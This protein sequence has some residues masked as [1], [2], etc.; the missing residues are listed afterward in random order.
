MNGHSTSRGHVEHKSLDDRLGELGYTPTLHRTLSV[1]QNVAIAMADVSPTMAVFLLATGALGI[2]G[3]GTLDAMLVV[4]VVVMM[5]SLCL[6]ELGAMYPLSG[7]MY[8]LIR[9]TLPGAWRTVGMFNLLIQGIIIPA[10]LILGAGTF[11]QQLWP[12]LPL[13]PSI[14]ALIL[15]AIVLGIA[16][17]TISFNARTMVVMFLV[18]VAVLSALTIGGLFHIH[19]SLSS[20][21]VHPVFLRSARLVPVSAGVLLAAFA[22]TYNIINGYDATLGLSEETRGTG[23]TI[24]WAVIGCAALAVLAMIIP[25][26]VSILSAPSWGAYLASTSPPIYS[27]T[28]ALGT[29]PGKVA[30]IGVTLA[31]FNSGL[32]C[33]VYYARV[34]FASGRDSVWPVGISRRLGMVNRFGAPWVALLVCV[35]PWA[36]LLFLS[37][38]NYLIVFTG[39]VLATEYFCIGV[40]AIWSRVSRATRSEDRPFKMPAWPVAPVLVVAGTGLA[41][42]QQGGEYQ[43]GEVVL[44]AAAI[45]YYYVERILPQYRPQSELADSVGSRSGKSPAV[46]EVP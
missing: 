23:R 2:G 24:A 15:T 34:W 45:A 21:I 6:G 13:T 39:S 25:L 46:E 26:G 30:E 38:L 12:G 14:I 19:H 40:A 37:T 22:P 3:T 16:L 8:S 32:A 36:L 9:Y 42:T 41:L 31:L 20:I 7:G 27:I 28:Q 18:E 11:I 43:I 5:I 44:C 1:W 4:G 35:V 33:F 29:W 10:S 17:R